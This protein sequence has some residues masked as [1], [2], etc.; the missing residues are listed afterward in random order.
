MTAVAFP[1]LVLAAALFGA[2]FMPGDWYLALKKPSWTPPNW[3]FGPVWTT[4]YVMIAAAGWLVWRAGDRGA[5]IAVWTA[6][7]VLNGLWSWLFFG[8]RLIGAA[9]VDIALIW[10]TIV[11]FIVLAWP[12]SRWASLLFLPY[13]AWVS[14]ATALNFTIW[15]LN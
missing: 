14:L 4:L 12:K 2:Q 10:A 7:I 1:I 15:R 8:Q 3:L 9:L 5:A 11:A 6:N 13:L